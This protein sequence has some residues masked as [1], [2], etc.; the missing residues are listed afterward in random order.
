MDGTMQEL[1]SFWTA[2]ARETAPAYPALSTDLEV[3]VAIVGGGIVGLTAAERLGRSGRSVAVLEAR[4]IGQQVTGRSTA[5][6]TSQHGLIYDRLIRDFGEEGARLYGEANEQAIRRIEAF[7]TELDIA[8]DFARTSAYVYAAKP[9]EHP[10]IE[11]EVEA[12]RRLGL[13]AAYVDQLPL[14][15]TTA[16]GMRFDG[17]A[18][19]QPYDYTLGLARSA[20]GAGRIF[21]RTRVTAIE[22]GEPC[23]VRTEAGAT[24][25]A[26]DAIVATHIP[27]GKIG[28]FFAKAFPYA[29]PVVAARV[30][31]TRTVDGMFI[32]AGSPTRS[33]RFARHAGQTY[34]VAAGDSYK[35]G[36]ADEQEQA[37]AD[38]DRFLSEAFG[39]TASDYRW[40]NEDFNAMDGVP[41]IGRS[42]G[43]RHEFVA[44]GFNAWGLTGGTVAAMLL[45]DL[46]A[47]RANPWAELFNAGRAK[48][49]AGGPSFLKENVHAARHLV[50]ERV[51]KRRPDAAATIGPGE[52]VIIDLDGEQVAVHRDTEGRLHAVSAICTHMGCVVGWNGVDRTWDCSCH[53]S[54]FGL[55]G[56]VI[57]GPAVSPLE[58]KSP[59]AG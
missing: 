20:A 34:L 18:Q 25:T 16:G 14:P 8:C 35:P 32:S 59:P 24:V 13:P 30:D 31:A 23:A 39:V 47:G 10:Q 42:P 51:L 22:D 40:T 26:K 1:P 12:A 2:T 50:S 4:R 11:R 7:V 55:D 29:H 38:L 46:I 5:K 56:G 28:L 27:I 19:F 43:S 45:T 54:R 49:V 33:V 48:P 53:G 44:T 37:F 17:Q 15:F 21:E 3:D 58:K 57:H 6:V 9:E 52:G 36:H 41:F